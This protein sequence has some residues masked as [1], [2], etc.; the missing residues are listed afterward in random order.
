MLGHELRNPLAAVRSATE[1]LKHLDGAEPRLR[2]ASGVLER[3]T[4]HMARLIDGLLEVSR[5]ARGK[6]DLSTEILDL[7]KLLTTVLEDRKPQF[8]A[9][10][11]ACRTNLPGQAVWVCGDA[12]R[13]AQIF[14]NLLG[15]ALKFTHPAGC[16][17][18]DLGA[19]ATWARVRVRDTGVGIREE[20]LDRIFEPFYQEKQD[21]ARAAGGLGLG[22][23]LVKGLV[24]LH[25]GKIEA[26][27]AGPG[28]GTEFRI[29][30][31][32]S[33]GPAAAVQ[34]QSELLLM[35]RRILIVEDNPDAGQALQDLLEMQGHKVA[36]AVTAP[37]ALSLLWKE[38]A[39][40]VICDLG[41]PG[42][43]GYEL[44][45]AIRGDEDLKRIPLLALTGYGQPEDRQRS[46]AA[47]FNAHLTKPVDLGALDKALRRLGSA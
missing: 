6:I 45:R 39:D 29:H 10:Q 36:V 21:I 1:V 42:M 26:S 8:D 24:E 13:L 11:I 12:V 30:L 44:A 19:D 37:Q 3:Q 27:S 18:I 46:Q 40:I 31:P 22:L 33:S 32:V 41:L 7:G 9:R 14:D 5:I 23:P 20:M 4:T 43:S 2:R 17:T 16:I 15:N 35:P 47:G 28:E 25:G 38:G 34:V